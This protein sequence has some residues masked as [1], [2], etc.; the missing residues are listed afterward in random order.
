MWL[1]RLLK[2]Q[3][4]TNRDKNSSGSL[5]RFLNCIC[6]YYMLLSC[7]Q[8]MGMQWCPQ[9]PENWTLSP[10]PLASMLLATVAHFIR[11]ENLACVLGW[12]WIKCCLCCIAD[13]CII[14]IVSE[15]WSSYRQPASWPLLRC[16]CLLAI[17]MVFTMV[18]H[19]NQEFV[20]CVCLIHCFCD[21]MLSMLS[22]DLSKWSLAPSNRHFL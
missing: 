4:L 14:G 19:C 7:A 21:K 5:R 15:D 6:L 16:F 22:W 12:C 8:Y 17:N 18:A 20:N 3:I 10:Y 9:W 1:K 2:L 11:G 13:C